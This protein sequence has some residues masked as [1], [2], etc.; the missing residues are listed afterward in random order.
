MELELFN[1]FIIATDS[2]GQGCLG[3]FV[4]DSKQRVQWIC[5]GEGKDLDRLEGWP[6]VNLMVFNKTTATFST[7]FKRYERACKKDREKYLLPRPAVT[8][9]RATVL[10]W[11]KIGLG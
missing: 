7:P 2:G 10:H 9:Q 8:G 11:K 1:I 5:L 6:C 4:D 3:R